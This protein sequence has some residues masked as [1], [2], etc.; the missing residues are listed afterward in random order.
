MLTLHVKVFALMRFFTV[1]CLAPTLSPRLQLPYSC[2]SILQ[3]N[4]NSNHKD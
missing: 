1:T 4:M 2:S 3:A